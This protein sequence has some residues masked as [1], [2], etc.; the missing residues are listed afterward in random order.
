MWGISESDLPK[1]FSNGSG[2]LVPAQKQSP[3]R[4]IQAHSSGY[5][6]QT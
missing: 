3:Q 5:Q 1:L 2:F 4:W 6:Q